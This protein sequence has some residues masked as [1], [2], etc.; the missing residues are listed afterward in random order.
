ME[1]VEIIFVFED[2]EVPFKCSKEETINDIFQENIL[3]LGED[4]NSFLFYY[5]EHELNLELCFD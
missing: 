2:F 3:E 5:K 1:E 4:I